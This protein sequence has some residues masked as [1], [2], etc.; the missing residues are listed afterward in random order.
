LAPDRD[1]LRADLDERCSLFIALNALPPKSGYRGLIGTTNLN[2]FLGDG[3][4]RLYDRHFGKKPRAKRA[5]S[6]SRNPTKHAPPGG[7]YVRFALAVM[8]ELGQK[9]SPHTVDAAIKAVRKRD[10]VFEPDPKEGETTD[11]FIFRD[12]CWQDNG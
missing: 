3:L 9:I 7:P 10:P 12:G 11:G 2:Q 8:R 6:R 4:A 1:K 5:G